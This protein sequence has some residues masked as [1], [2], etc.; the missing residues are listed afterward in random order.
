MEAGK[1]VPDDIMVRM[2]AERIERPDCRTGFVLDGFPRTVRQA[3]ALDEML[4]GKGLKLDA[5]IEMKVDDEALIRR[6]AGRF[7]CATCGA[8]YH[9]ET[10]RPKVS[11]VCDKCGGREF[12]RRPDDNTETVKARLAAYHAQTAP[13]LPYYAKRG[14]LRSVD[15][16]APIDEVSRQLES[17]L[18]AA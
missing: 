5:V 14:V 4:A 8:V 12:V 16:M 11:G 18:E 17:L 13:L 3:E 1:L 2:I 15:G 9:D 6:I 7:S 10:K